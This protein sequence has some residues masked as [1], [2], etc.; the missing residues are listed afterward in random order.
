[1]RSSHQLIW[2]SPVLDREALD[3][4][5]SH[6]ERALRNAGFS[7]PANSATSAL[8][9]EPRDSLHLRFDLPEPAPGLSPELI[10]DT[11]WREVLSGALPV[12][13]P[14]AVACLSRKTLETPKKLVCFDM[15]STLIDQEV[16]DEIARK[17][18]FYEEVSAI[19]EQSMQGKLDFEQSLRAR[20]ALFRGLEQERVT[21]VIS[22][23]TVSPGGKEL[24]SS[25]RSQG[26]R[27]AV[28]SGGFE[29]ILEHFKKTL[30]LDHV[31]GNALAADANGLLTGE[32]EGRIV[33]AARKREIV[34]ELK[35]RLGLSRDEVI[36]AGDGANDILMME[37]AGTSVS[38]CG[39]P[40]LASKANTLIFDRN[41]LWM[42][43]FL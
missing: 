12:P 1:M 15:D 17:A 6:L 22:S 25:L 20:V 19:T 40:R 2:I 21:E 13:R 14:F 32:L 4:L 28:I 26:I 33:D 10:K 8:L 16:I 38:F 18:G 42:K 35:N 24:L 34:S 9:H 29:V 5:S 11:V 37:E 39:K 23:L 3:A 41:L 31:F 27:T 7:F 30:G 36:V 43:M